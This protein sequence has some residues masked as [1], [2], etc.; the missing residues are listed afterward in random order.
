MKYLRDKGLYVQWY[1]ST[2]NTT[3]KIQYQNQFNG[4][5]SPFVQDS[6]LGRVSDS[7]FLNYVWN[8]KMLHDSRDHALSLG[9]DPLETVFAGVEGGHDKFGRWKQSYDLRHN[10]DENGQPMNS[11]MTLGADFTH[12][13]L[14]EEMGD[15]STNHRAEDEYQW[16]TF[17][18]D[19]AWW[20]GPNQ[21]PT[22]ARHVRLPI[23]PMCMLPVQIGMESLHILPNVPSSMA[24]ILQQ[25][26]I[27]ATV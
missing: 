15:G 9:L 22:D 10:L 14:D 4:L 8:H 5:N 2:I 26:S 3:G 27:R 24:L 23:C 19:R 16:M 6:V 25:V 7:I 1:D 20:S 17:V 12:N 18:R 21:D 13:A 11:I